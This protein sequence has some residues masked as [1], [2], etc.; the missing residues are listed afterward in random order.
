[1][2]KVQEISKTYDTIKAVD[3]V[4]FTLRKG[5]IT[6]M[7]GA[8]G[9]G[10]STILKII[11]GLVKRDAGEIYLD[12]KLVGRNFHRITEITGYMPERFSL[13]TDLSVEENLNFYSDIRRV[14]R[15]R[16]EEMKNR[17]LAKT[18]MLPFRKRRA[19]ALSGGMK[20]KLA[21]SSIL[22]ASPEIIILDEPT[23][24]VDPLSR[25]EFFNIVEELKGEGKTIV[26]ATPY[27]DEAEKGDEV[28]FVKDGKVLRE[29][30]IAS[31]KAAFPAKLFRILP[32]GNILEIMQILR[33]DPD[34]KDDVYVRGRFIKFLQREGRT[35]PVQIPV[36]EIR[37]ESPTLEDIYLYHERIG[38]ATER[39]E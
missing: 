31:L 20:Q 6:I 35:F 8:D 12:G 18:G 17:L 11:L 30:S 15:L 33:E 29:G 36:R 27:L 22:L 37:E 32:E 13:Y 4:S 16:R 2:L 34:V 10:K 7:A 21:L 28:I 1:M 39:V 25:F 14:P 19:G 38:H 5:T 23:T 26:M 9:A 24:G 3:A